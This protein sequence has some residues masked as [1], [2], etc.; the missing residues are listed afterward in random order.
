[1]SGTRRAVFLDRDGTL[2]EDLDYP[3]EAER[4]RLLD[5]VGAGLRALRDA[6]FMLVVI[7]N[8]SGIGRGIIDPDEAKAV[9]E[10]FVAE[11]RA[12]HIE[13]DGVW[14]CPHAPWVQCDCRKP[15][16]AMLL[17]AAEQLDVALAESFR[18]GDKLSDAQAGHRAGCRTV[19]LGGGGDDDGDRGRGADDDA[20]DET[21]SDWTAVVRLILSEDG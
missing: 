20:V 1:V 14:Y 4:V 7:S 19:V 11:L 17:R 6:G 18:V 15:Q 16:P 2:I 5:G 21:A 10:R 12:E 9:H 13:L 3:R 8:Q